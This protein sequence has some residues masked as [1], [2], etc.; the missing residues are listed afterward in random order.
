VPHAI[1]LPSLVTERPQRQRGER[2]G[3]TRC[4]AA[5]K[6]GRRGGP[7]LMQGAAGKSASKGLVEG[8]HAEADE[9]AVLAR[10]DRKICN[11]ASQCMQGFRSFADGDHGLL[12]CLFMFCSRILQPG[13]D[14]KRCFKADPSAGSGSP[15][16][17]FERYEKILN[18]DDDAVT[19]TKAVSSEVGQ[20]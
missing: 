1:P 5:M 4:C 2:Q 19:P 18:S 9:T 13:A 6:R 8:C 3:K 7:D 14:V 17:R 10:Q 16:L 11:G 15:N 12:I 20:N